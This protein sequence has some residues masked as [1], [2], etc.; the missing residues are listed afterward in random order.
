MGIVALIAEYVQPKWVL[1]ASSVILTI[2]IIIGVW[3]SSNKGLMG[4]DYD[5]EIELGK[6]ERDAIG[7]TT[8]GLST[9]D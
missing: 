4:S 3:Y 6:I 2:T 8:L 9:D 1:F 5:E 7:G